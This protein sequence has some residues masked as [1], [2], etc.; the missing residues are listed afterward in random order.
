MVAGIGKKDL[1]IGNC[2]SLT[3]FDRDA[4]SGKDSPMD[5]YLEQ[6]KHVSSPVPS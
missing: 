2:L 1:R 3:L 4:Y 6:K 5:V